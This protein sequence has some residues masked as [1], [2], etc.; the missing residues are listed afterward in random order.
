[1]PPATP[2]ASNG[3]RADRWDY[4]GY[5]KPPR[6]E[7]TSRTVSLFFDGDRLVRMEGDEGTGKGAVPDL[8]TIEAEQKKAEVE[9]ERAEEQKKDGGI[10]TPP[11]QQDHEG[12]EKAR[13]DGAGQRVHG[14]APPG[15]MS[16]HWWISPTRACG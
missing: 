5:Y 1:M 12:A 14:A 4:Y 13:V 7:G 8:K 11:D 10:I 6:G 3:L 15:S 16:C 9:K 2:I